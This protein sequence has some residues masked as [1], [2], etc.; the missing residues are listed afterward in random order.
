MAVSF[1]IFAFFVAVGEYIIYFYLYETKGRTD[2]EIENLFT[3]K[4]KFVASEKQ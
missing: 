4:N 2:S 3:S 1:L